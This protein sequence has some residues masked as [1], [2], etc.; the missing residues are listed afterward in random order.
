MQYLITMNINY[1]LFISDSGRA[2]NSTLENRPTVHLGH[3]HRYQLYYQSGGGGGGMQPE[4]KHGS[5]RVL[6]YITAAG[7][8]ISS[9]LGSSCQGDRYGTDKAGR[10][11]PLRPSRTKSHLPG[12]SPPA[13]QVCRRVGPALWLSASLDAATASWFLILSSGNYILKMK[14]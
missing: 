9:Q 4:R 8:Y 6:N 5:T 11:R 10:V 2:S 13:S 3:A 14:A 12:H 7:N 1:Y